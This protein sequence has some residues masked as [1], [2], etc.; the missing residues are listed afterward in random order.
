MKSFQLLLPYFKKNRLIIAAGV[1][2][3]IIVDLLQLIIPRII[4]S[5]ID[6]LTTFA[7]SPKGLLIYAAEILLIALL[8]AVFRYL[9]RRCLIGMSRE[10]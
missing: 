1:V 9:W 2:C 3:L 5:V 4:K 7:I 10:V 6:D 8:M